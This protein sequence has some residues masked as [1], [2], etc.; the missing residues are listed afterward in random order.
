MPSYLT[1]LAKK[2]AMPAF[3]FHCVPR[4]AQH[5]AWYIV[6]A[7]LLVEGMNGVFNKDLGV[8]FLR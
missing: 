8:C 3:F 1:K 4:S 5:N 2:V 7:Y 6:G